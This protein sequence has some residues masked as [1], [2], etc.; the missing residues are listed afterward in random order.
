MLGLKIG[1]DIDGVVANSFPVFLRELNKH[2]GKN[3]AQIDN[4]KM[5]ELYEVSEDDL[6]AFFNEN[7][8]YL[9]SAPEPIAGALASIEAWFQ[10]GHEIIFITARK[11]GIEERVTRKW[12]QKYGL[13]DEKIIFVGGASKTFAVKEY[14]LD[15]FVEDFMSN[16]LEIAALGVPVLLLDAPYNQGK[17]PV[18]VTRCYNWEDIK[19][20]VAKLAKCKGLNL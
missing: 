11:L 2:Y 14:R 3:L 16:V 19:C 1:L 6:G 9:Y 10:A 17:L 15:V 18:G 5:T 20:E 4:Y 8:E 12:F 13:P 7:V